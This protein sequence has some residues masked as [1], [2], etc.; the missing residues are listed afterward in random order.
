MIVIGI[1]IAVLMLIAAPFVIW[2]VITGL[3]RLLWFVSKSAA[4]LLIF[5]LI[6]AGVYFIGDHNEKKL[7]EEIENAPK[8]EIVEVPE[9]PEVPEIVVCE[10]PSW[11]GD[12]NGFPEHW[13]ERPQIETRDYRKLPDPF[14]HGSSTLYNWIRKNQEKDFADRVGPKGPKGVEGPE[15]APIIKGD[16]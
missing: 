15:G 14:G 4:A 8:A 2:R 12:S 7:E 5:A 9:T 1:V 13:G 10:K 16:K 11:M 3:P 6:G